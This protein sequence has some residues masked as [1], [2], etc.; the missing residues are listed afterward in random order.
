MPHRFFI[1]FTWLVIIGVGLVLRLNDLADRP[2]HAD[3]ATGA[4]ILADRLEGN[5]YSFNPNHF[6]GPTLSLSSLPLTQ[7][8]EESSW[9]DL[10]K[11]TLRISP[12][13]AG[14]LLILTPLLWLKNIGSIGAITSGAF[15]ATSPLLVYYNRVY[16]HESW[17][18]LFS[19]LALSA[20]CRGNGRL[21]IS[22]SIAAGVSI[23][24][25]YA[26]K[27]TFIICVASWVLAVTAVCFFHK[28]QLPPFRKYVVPLIILAISAE[29]T[30]A[31][32]YSNGFRSLEGIIDAVRTYFVYETTEGHEKPF[33]FYLQQMLWPKHTLGLWWTEAGVALFALI[34]TFRRRRSALVIFLAL[35]TLIH[36]L[37]YSLI[38][39]KT[40]W[41]ML[42]PWAH[43]CLLT[44]FALNPR[45]VSKTEFPVYILLFLCLAFQ[46][47]QSNQ[48]SSRFENN[49]RNPYAYVPT[50]KN[51][52]TLSAWLSKLPL[53]DDAVIAVVG[54]QYWPLP[55]YLREFDNVGYWLDVAPDLGSKSV[56]IVTPEYQTEA[57]EV[58]EASHTGIPRSLR[59]NVAIQVYIANEIWELWI[60]S[61]E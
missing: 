19:I 61:E 49:A 15:L 20:L 27:E 31:L 57:R 14:C 11:V 33:H 50:S 54:A 56:V 58:L 26:T 40:P 3:E 47:Y 22:M 13:I 52:E 16:I 36:V 25:M 23:G 18:A 5:G 24:L 2:M 45:K 8:N 34:A 12:V 30:A 9:P 59:H 41:L 7:I 29:F 38:S 21:S 46:T 10:T 55:W 44:G 37:I 53:E 48:A 60:N 43:L 51:V 35:S 28:K 6:H 39:Y 1:V 4:R 32:L 42:A 17:F